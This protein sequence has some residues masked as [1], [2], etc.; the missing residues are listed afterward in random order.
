MNTLVN[1][2]LRPTETFE[3]LDDLYEEDLNINSTLITSAYGFLVGISVCLLE[4]SH[5]K[6]M[7]SGLGLV[8]IC[9]IGG[10]A[11]FAISVLIYNYLLT[12]ILYGFGRLLGGKGIVADTRTAIVYSLIPTAINL[13]SLLIPKLVSVTFLDSYFYYWVMRILFFIF[14]VWSMTILVKGLKTFNKYGTVRAIINIL[15]LVLIG[16]SLS[17]IEY[18]LN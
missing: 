12:S 2:L 8:I 13:I 3:Y 17:L 5:L 11:T 6:E 18:L 16:I 7:A 9:A 10:V 14:W 1:I 4:Y 15:P